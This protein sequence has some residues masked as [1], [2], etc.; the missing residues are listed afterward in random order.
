MFILRLRLPVFHQLLC[1]CFDL[2]LFN[3][4]WRHFSLRIS[5]L[6]NP[7][8]TI[9][10]LVFPRTHSHIRFQSRGD[11]RTLKSY[12]IIN[13]NTQRL[14]RGPEMLPHTQ[15]YMLYTIYNLSVLYT[16]SDE[17]V[18]YSYRRRRVCVGGAAHMHVTHVRLTTCL[19]H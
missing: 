9:V 4:F 3:E 5:T 11:L 13:I 16:V 12:L 19:G 14:Q 15:S 10:Y 18:F 17:R 6:F 7:F 2:N 1:G 8:T